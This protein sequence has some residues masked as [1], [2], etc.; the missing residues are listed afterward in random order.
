MYQA[1][2][3]IIYGNNGVFRVE[4]VDTPDIPGIDKGR[5]YYTLSSYYD[6]KRVYT[7]TDTTVL[8]RPVITNAMAHKLIAQIPS[9]E[10][11][12]YT[13][14]NIRLLEN[15]Y[16]AALKTC[17]CYHLIKLIKSVHAKNKIAV[18]RKKRPGQIDERFM[19]K[20]EDLLVDEFAVALEMPREDVGKYIEKR[21]SEIEKANDMVSRGEIYEYIK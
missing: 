3:L 14:N 10:G 5:L 4:A 7:P 19:R 17:D 1:G 13:G 8:I 9:I 6:S 2:D 11:N 21:I 20:A 18:E 15:H 12:V 16:Q